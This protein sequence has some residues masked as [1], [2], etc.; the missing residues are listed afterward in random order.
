MSIKN[1]SITKQ[2]KIFVRRE[3]KRKVSFDTLA[4]YAKRLGYI[5]IFY[6]LNEPND[7][8]I[9]YGLKTQ[10]S[11]KPALTVCKGNIKYIFINSDCSV[12]HKLIFLAH[13]IA[14][15][16]LGHLDID[17]NIFD[18]E[19]CEIEADTFAYEML[20]Y[21]SRTKLIWLILTLSI[22]LCISI[23]FGIY[24]SNK[25]QYD[26]YIYEPAQVEMVYITPTGT[27][28]H[29]ASCMYVQNKNC[30]SMQRTEALK[31][32]EPCKVCNP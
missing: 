26:N 24:S 18:T 2:A 30:A 4:Q 14:H 12:E 8:I 23:G 21:K 16:V 11:N 10:L 5:I 27:K 25:P 28:F 3:L 29:R 13:E 15:I 6:R 20:H 19:L 7:I 1:N 22:A 31:S 9:K 32:F 17:K